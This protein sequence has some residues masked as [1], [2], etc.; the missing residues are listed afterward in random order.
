MKFLTHRN[1][2]GYKNHLVGEDTTIGVDKV[3]THTE[4]QF[5]EHGSLV[6][7]EA[8]KKL[9]DLHVIAY[10]DIFLCVDTKIAVGKV[11]FNLVNTCYSIKTFL[12]ET[13]GFHGTISMQNLSLILL[14][15][16]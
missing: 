3:P 13:V 15:P 9:R 5:A 6:Q 10:G 12:K 16:Y 1:C 8:V 14:H 2:R 7:D 11:E 4:F